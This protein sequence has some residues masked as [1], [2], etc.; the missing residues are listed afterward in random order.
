MVWSSTYNTHLNRI[1]LLQ[2]RAIRAFTNSEY[3]AHTAP[4]FAKL[5]DFR[6]IWYFY[7]PCGQIY[8][9]LCPNYFNQ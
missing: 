6:Y 3:R 4:L 9:Q 2:E 7:V 8:V 5:Q 1:Y